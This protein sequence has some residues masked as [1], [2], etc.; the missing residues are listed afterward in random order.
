MTRAQEI[1]DRLI[2]LEAEVEAATAACHATQAA[3]RAALQTE[4]GATGHLCLKSNAGLA[5]MQALQGGKWC[6]VCGYH[7][8]Q[9]SLSELMY[10]AMST[11]TLTLVPPPKLDS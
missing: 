3:E 11:P 10:E 8:P 5:L 7:E 1:I 2:A 4:C 6:A 9:R